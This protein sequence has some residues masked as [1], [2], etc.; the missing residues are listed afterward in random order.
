MKWYENLW[1]VILGLIW[2]KFLLD[3]V[4]NLICEDGK[5]FKFWVQ[6]HIW[7]VF[8]TSLAYWIYNKF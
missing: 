8:A 4:Y 6:I 5:K 7:S 2:I 3:A 1:I